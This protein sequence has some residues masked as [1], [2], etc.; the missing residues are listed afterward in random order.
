VSASPMRLPRWVRAALSV[1]VPAVIR[2]EIT[3]DLEERFSSI[4]ADRGGV[5]AHVWVVGQLVRMRPRELRRA[6]GEGGGMGGSDGWLGD[7]RHALRSV[8]LR[9]GFSATVIGTVAIAV[10]ATTSVFSVVNGVLLRPLD[11]PEPERLVLAWQTNPEWAE[12]PSSQ[13]RAF[14]SRFPLSVPT[15]FDWEEGRTG[16]DA[17]GIHASRRWVMQG[18]DGADV[19]RGG[20]FTSGVFRALRVDPLMGRYLVPDDDRAG[21]QPVAVLSHGSWRDRFGSD[22]EILD[23]SISLDGLT[24]T[25]VGVMPPGFTVPRADGEIWS[26]LQDEERDDRGSQGYMVLGRLADGA[27]VESVQADLDVIQTRLSDVYPLQQRS[28]RSRTQGLLDYLVGDV[29]STLFFLLAAVGLV[30]TIACVNIANMLSVGGL[31]R[32]REMAVRAALGAS[33]GRLVR[34]LLTESAVLAGLGGLGGIL[35]AAATLPGLLRILPASL[36]R[37][38][39][40]GVDGTVLAFGLFVTAAT[41][42]LVGVLPA[43]HAAGTQPRQ[44]MDA[45]SRGLAG[46][47]SGH[48][49]RTGLVVTEVALAFVLLVGA[50]L[51]T[52]SFNK[53]WNVE[54]GFQSE[55]LVALHAAPNETE[56][57]ERE[58]RRRF[59]SEVRERLEAIPG[60]QVTRTNQVPL[61]GSSSSTTYYF[62]RDGE[63]QEVTVM[64]S[65]VDQSYFEVMEIGIAEGRSFDGSEVVDGPLVG[66]VNQAFVDEIFP[67]ESALGRRVRAQSRDEPRA[68]SGDGASGSGPGPLPE[69]TIIGIAR[70]VRHQGLHVP[71]EPKLYVPASQNHRNADDWLLRVQGDPTAVMELARQAVTAVSP[72]TPVRGLQL[73]E[74]AI[75]SSV[76]VP[77]FRTMFVVGL[78]LMATVLALLGVYGVVTFAVSQRT[79]ELAVRMA[80]GAHP[81]DVV[82]GT[83]SSGLKLALAGVALGGVIAVWANR[84]LEQFLYEVDPTQPGTYLLVALVVGLVTAGASWLP[85]RRAARV[86]PVSVLNTE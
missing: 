54:R 41:A 85:A 29:R 57:P 36:P 71:A 58:D 26:S 74:E 25:V 40:I 7:V 3:G 63:E 83:L 19:V 61:S 11:Y 67:G 27:T 14:A 15:F 50:S 75:A 39:A 42:M 13:L 53:L 1:L 9:I 32:R 86:D 65:V 30:L 82:A 79:R 33:R 22:P 31:A 72:S 24:Y 16:F 69:T 77:R 21:A 68:P 64:I 18:A 56:Y 80:I 70:D 52:T 66:I 35:L 55:G 6:L 46:G 12:H 62:D 73:L 34:S 5:Q 44:M 81:R 76:A 45:N 78:A 8:R 28:M 37:G 43:L 4:A 47:R 10:G 17:F 48:R 60:V 49:I 23:R 2:E 59:T 84:L 38:E 51:L 20:M